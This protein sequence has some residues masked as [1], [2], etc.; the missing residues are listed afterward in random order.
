M[1][2]DY[3]GSAVY[4]V[5]GS[6]GIGLAAAKAFAERGADVL[7][8][9][10]RREPLE[11]AAREVER[12]R[13]SDEQRVGFRTLDV[14]DAG[15]VESVMS[16]AV[17]S[18]GVPDVLFNCAG[19][20][21]P[22]YFEE[23]PAGQLEEIMRVNLFGTWSTVQTLLP[24]MKGRGGTI[25]NTSSL[26]GLVGVFGY[27]DYCAAKFAVIGF[28]EALRSELAR[29]G[30]RV[31]VLC[32]PDTETPGL[33]DE[34]RTKPP[35]TRAVSAGARCLSAEEVAATLL[36][37]MDRRALLIIPGREARWIALAKRLFPRL[38]ERITDRAVAR[39]GSSSA[40]T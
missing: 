16:E 6:M 31:F 11:T 37:G 7:L 1:A 2:Q 26:A 4:V 36:R 17:S 10:R 15:A 21:Q 3:Q 23:I 35:E 22:G 9:A 30:M 40:S 38:V 27:T 8:F 14:C 5:G 25:V 32:P 20:A 39:A 13:R 12:S 33:E 18:C 34:S 29:H 19:R 24:H 28:S